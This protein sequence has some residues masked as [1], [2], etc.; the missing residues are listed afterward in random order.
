[1]AKMDAL[2]IATSMAGVPPPVKL[3]L[4][5]DMGGGACRDGSEHNV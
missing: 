3:I 5:T 1:M 4:D 2:W